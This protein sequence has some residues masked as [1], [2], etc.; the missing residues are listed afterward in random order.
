MKIDHNEKKYCIDIKS[1]D[2]GYWP[3]VVFSAECTI[4]VVLGLPSAKTLWN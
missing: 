2:E 1:D 4:G 3:S